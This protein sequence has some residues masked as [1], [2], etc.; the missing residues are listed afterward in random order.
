MLKLTADAIKMVILEGLHPF[1]LSNLSLFSIQR[2]CL[3]LFKDVLWSHVGGPAQS[4]QPSLP[5]KVLTSLPLPPS[6]KL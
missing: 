5:I 3:E 6:N 4:S 2:H 1:F